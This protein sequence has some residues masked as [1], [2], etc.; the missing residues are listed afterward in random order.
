MYVENDVSS[1]RSGRVYDEIVDAVQHRGVTEVALYGFSHD[2][3]SIYDL[4]ERPPANQAS[5]GVFEAI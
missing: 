1:D 2:G 4:T 5:I 3:G